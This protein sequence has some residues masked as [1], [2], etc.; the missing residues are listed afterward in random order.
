MNLPP[1]LTWLQLL[2]RAATCVC[3]P[4][5]PAWL[6]EKLRDCG[7]HD[8]TALDRVLVTSNREWEDLVKLTDYRRVVAINSPGVTTRQLEAAGFTYA[9]RFAVVPGLAN[10][11]WFASID[12]GR[13]AAGSL[14]VYTPARKSAHVKKALA[15]VAARLNLPGWYRDQIVIASR[16]LPP[17][18]R[19]L[20][21]L[22][23]G[24]AIR[25]GLSSGAPELALNRK[26]SAAIMAESGRV[27]GFAKIAGSSISRR[28][29]EHEGQVLPVLAD[30]GLA[31]Q[32]IY[33]GEVD[34]RFVTVQSPLPGKPAPLAFTPAHEQ[35][36][37]SLRTRTPRI[38]AETRM[39]ATLP[40]RIATLP[41]LSGELQ[42]A[43]TRVLPTL[44]ET[45][46]GATIV[47]G[48]FAPW[49]LRLHA[50]RISAF[51]WEYA[52]L[53]GLPLIDQ[54]HFILQVGFQLHQWSV[55]R[56]AQCLRDISQA[57]P[58]GLEPAQA[59]AI[60]A[61]YLIDNLVRLLG[62]G[63]D[64]ADEML[65][66]HRRLLLSL[67]AAGNFKSREAALVA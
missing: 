53:D 15:R 6:A 30:R 25:I 2:P 10:A 40:Q 31:P 9:R 38:A 64:A 46:V 26:A 42:A 13:A 50:G 47:H 54:T 65:A 56:A 58:L 36:L 7:R 34:G 20:R 35:F 21:E 11:R 32:L 5:V 24:E 67:L 14:S 22:F 45:T 62:E 1:A 52:E 8:G 19:K 59:T 17:L 66:W 43:L 37:A 16:E 44:E 57:R 63:Y 27:I 29:L 61:V 33:A 12:S 18:E 39:L 23:P 55:D 48:D 49:N 3:D 28:I 60:Q 41:A 4:S 51:D